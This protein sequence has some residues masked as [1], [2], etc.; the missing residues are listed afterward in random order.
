MDYL[1]SVLFWIHLVALAMGGVA[2]FGIPVAGSKMATATAETRPLL[3][4][5]VE[6]LSR[7]GRI[8]LGLLIITGPLLVWLKYGG[9]SGFTFWFWVK[10]VLVVILLGIVIF[11]GINGKRA[12]SGDMAA[13][14]R[15][16]QIGMAGM[17]TF[18]LVVAAAVLAFD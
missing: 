11:A 18:L 10:M 14:K 2:T 5:I 15:S 3:F 17:I 13:A 1:N 8:G 7:I 6:G 9:I 12:Q 4:A 16:P